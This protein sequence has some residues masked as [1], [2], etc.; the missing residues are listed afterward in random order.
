MPFVGGMSWPPT[1][2]ETNEGVVED[3][4]H[5][6]TVSDRYFEAMSIPVVS[7]RMFNATDLEDT[8]PVIVVNEAFAK[9]YWPDEVPIGRRVRRDFPGDSIWRTVVG[10]VGDIRNRLDEDPFPEFFLPT[11]QDP[12]WYQIVVIKAGIEPAALI[13]Q[14][15]DALWAIDRDVPAY[16]RALDDRI[17]SSGAVAGPRF[18]VF[19]LGLLSGLAALLAI[20]G[21]YGVLAY[22]VSQRSKEIGIRMALGA[23]R[24]SVVG[25]VLKRGLLMAGGGLAIGVGISFAAGRVIESQLFEVRATDPLTMVSVGLLILAATVAAS[26]IPA[27]RATKVDPVEALRNE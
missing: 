22:T 13:P 9:Q 14:I 3:I 16:A 12:W 8:E 21:I 19:I 7:G 2:V 4:V 5:S 25:G 6:S 18:G 1:S 26:Y 15:R 10:V 17:N 24:H 23:G 27:W 11:S 20:V